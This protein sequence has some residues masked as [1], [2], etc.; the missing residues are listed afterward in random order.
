MSD[1]LAE[2]PVVTRDW[3]PGCEPDVDPLRALVRES[4]CGHHIPSQRGVDDDRV[5]AAEW[6][7]LATG[8]LNAE[9]NRAMN[10]LLARSRP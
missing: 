3:C 4:W 1:D 6:F 2:T 8:E 10:A 7:V 5:I 9:T